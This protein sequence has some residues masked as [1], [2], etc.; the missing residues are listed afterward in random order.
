[1]RTQIITLIDVT[2]TNARRDGDEKEYS[3]QSNFNT[4]C[5]TASLR[6]NL[7]PIKVESK[8]GGIAT[9]GFGN[10]YKGK[11]RYW[12][13]TFDD[14]RD[15]PITQEMF[16]DDFDMIPMVLDLDETLKIDE[17]AL[18]TK[19]EDKLNIVFKNIDS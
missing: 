1:M 6:A 19:D 5:Q 14:E 11:H 9:I 18:Y 7:V 2:Q 16:A 8:F 17:G 10:D 3:Q 13:V 15:T 4:L 12:V